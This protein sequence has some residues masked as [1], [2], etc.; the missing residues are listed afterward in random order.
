[1]KRTLVRRPKPMLLAGVEQEGGVSPYQCAAAGRDLTA[2][3]IDS[4]VRSRCWSSK[5]S[6]SARPPDDRL[7]R[8]GQQEH[9][10]RQAQRDP[11]IPQPDRR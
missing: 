1:M 9:Q 3:V 4:V 2:I 11:P 6:T 5:R 10:D 7:A 8:L